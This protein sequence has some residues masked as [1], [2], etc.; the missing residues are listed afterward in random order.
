MRLFYGRKKR[1]GKKRNP[2]E[3]TRELQYPSAASRS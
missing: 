1:G 2:D 3:H